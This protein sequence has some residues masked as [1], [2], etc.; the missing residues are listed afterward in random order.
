MLLYFAHMNKY[1]SWYMVFIV[2]VYSRKADKYRYKFF[3]F[4][5]NCTSDMFLLICGSEKFSTSLISILY[6]IWVWFRKFVV[7]LKEKHPRR[8]QCPR[9]YV[10]NVYTSSPQ[11]LKSIM[12]IYITLGLSFILGEAK[13][14]EISALI[15]LICPA[16]MVR[17]LGDGKWGDKL[18][19]QRSFFWIAGVWTNK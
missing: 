5:P 14:S 19:S 2:V 10:E 11:M 4:I 9:E 13:N 18:N 3:F 16:D 12:Y 8:R 1:N 15:K 6:G 7:L 17:I